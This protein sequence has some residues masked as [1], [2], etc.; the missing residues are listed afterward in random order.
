MPT[1]KTKSNAAKKENENIS[2]SKNLEKLNTIAAWFDDQEEIDIEIGLAKVKEAA[3][4]IKESRGRL[5]E[6]ENE[7][8]EIKLE[9]ETEEE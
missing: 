4:L 3:S 7:F 8:A 1:N 6:I 2:L 9:I 5:A